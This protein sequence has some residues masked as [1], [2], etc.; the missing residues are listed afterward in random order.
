MGARES[1]RSVTRCRGIDGREGL[2]E[3]S[4]EVCDDAELQG[5]TGEHR[6]GLTLTV[7]NG[8]SAEQQP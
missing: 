3:S 7:D 1:E 6:N 4:R 5:M 8:V 2:P